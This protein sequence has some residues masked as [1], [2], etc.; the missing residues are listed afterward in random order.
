MTPQRIHLPGD[1]STF[2]RQS[3]CLEIGGLLL[4]EFLQ[5]EVMLARA[6]ARDRIAAEAHYAKTWRRISAYVLSGTIPA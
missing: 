2:S 4:E 6:G 1:S 5:A 3:G